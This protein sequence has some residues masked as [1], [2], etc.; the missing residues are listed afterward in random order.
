MIETVEKK[1]RRRRLALSLRMMML[2]VVVVGVLLAWKINRARAQRHAIKVIEGVGGEVL[3]DYQYCDQKFTLDRKPQEPGSLRELV[4]DDYSHDVTSVRLFCRT[5]DATPLKRLMAFPNLERLYLIGGNA[6][7][8]QLVYIKGLSRLRALDLTG[9][10]V[11]D[12][13]MACLCDLRELREL[14]ISDRPVTDA[15]LRYITNL[16]KLRSVTLSNT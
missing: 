3:L 6:S 10:R 16:T 12:R 9:T 2:L 5:P 1:P 14:N 15:G 4:G 11:T 13:G 8:E 7:N